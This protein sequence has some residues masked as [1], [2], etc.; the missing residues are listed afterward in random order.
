VYVIGGDILFSGAFRHTSYRL[1][2]P[3]QLANLDLVTPTGL[4]Q[5]ETKP[6]YYSSGFFPSG[7]GQTSVG[8]TLLGS[9][10][11]GLNTVL[12]ALIGRIAGGSHSPGT[13]VAT[14][15]GVGAPP[16]TP[17]GIA[18]AVQQHPIAAVG[19]A[20]AGGALT[21]AAGRGALQSVGL[22]G[23]GHARYGTP[24]QKGY[25]MIKKGPHAG[26]WARNRRR[27]V[28]NIRA[29]RRA[30]SRAHGFERICRKVTHFT[31]PGKARGRAVFKR[32]RRS[33]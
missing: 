24:G 12:P 4:Q 22:L 17:S 7:A 25:H 32:R 16:T 21:M 15:K 13:A 19:T 8:G 26:M 18:G 27:N 20:I 9:L 29:L 10:T 14:T 6:M 5:G 3:A 33:R 30:L 2:T 1:N 23:S 28:G 31:H 11:S